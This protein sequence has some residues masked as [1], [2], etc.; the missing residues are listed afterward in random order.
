MIISKRLSVCDCEATTTCEKLGSSKW[1]LNLSK[2]L[3]YLTF[4]LH[5]GNGG[6]CC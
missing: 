3:F 6:S 5:N 2:A 1:F 4:L